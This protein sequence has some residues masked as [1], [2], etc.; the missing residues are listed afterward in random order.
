MGKEEQGFG[1][2]V[3]SKSRLK[4]KALRLSIVFSHHMHRN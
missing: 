4:Q 1:L 2:K 3:M